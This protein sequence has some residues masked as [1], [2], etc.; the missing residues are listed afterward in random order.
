M[1]GE[2][3][4]EYKI[5]GETVNIDDKFVIATLMA[6]VFMLNQLHET[7]DLDA[8]IEGVARAIYNEIEEVQHAGTERPTSSDGQT[9][10]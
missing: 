9:A 7:P 10:G 5:A 8:V 3:G 2:E 4:R 1:Y 6:V